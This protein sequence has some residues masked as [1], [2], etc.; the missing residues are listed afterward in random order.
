M[1]KGAENKVAVKTVSREEEERKEILRQYRKLIE[2]W[3]TDKTTQNKW[4][5]RKAFKLAAEA[6]KD[7]RRKSGEPFI[8][9]PI[10]KYESASITRSK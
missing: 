10:S 3:E 8:F 1:D 9:H 5:V 7:M 6:H 2:V 4:E